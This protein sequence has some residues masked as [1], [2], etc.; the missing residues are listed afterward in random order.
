MLAARHRLLALITALLLAAPAAAAEVDKYLLDDTDALLT[1]NVRNAIDSPVFKK[2]YLP[3]V[4]KLLKEKPELHKH[5]LDAGLDPLKDIDRL[6]VVHGDSCHRDNDRAGVLV[7]AHGR[8]DS[9]RVQAKLGFL[10]QFAPKLLQIHK[11]NNGIVYELTLEDKSFFLAFPDRTTLVASPFK[12]QISDAL[13]KGANKKK[14]QLKFKDVKKLIEVTDSKQALWLLATGRTTTSV[15]ALGK[16]GEKVSKS[17]L[18]DQGVNEVSGGFLIT[19]GLKAAF[20]IK[21]ESEIAAKAVSEALQAELAKVVE[22][23][24]DGALDDPKLEPVRVFL[25]NLVIAGDGKYIV[26]QGEVAPRIFADSVK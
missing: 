15:V 19:D 18:K 25:K 17:T 2:V 24:F 7:V 4:Q 3:L 8:F 16:K 12:D 14:P 1:L 22:K 13:D 23:G 11:E 5:L 26:I 21:V 10:A 9:G 20:G 6:L